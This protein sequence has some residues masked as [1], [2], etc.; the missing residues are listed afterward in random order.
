MRPDLIPQILLGLA[1][2]GAGGALLSYLSRGKNGAAWLKATPLQAIIY[3]AAIGAMLGVIGGPLRSTAH[4]SNEHTVHIAS[5]GDFQTKVL[6]A[7]QPV[8]VDFFATWCPPCHELAPTIERLS[9]EYAGKAVIAKVDV[10][11]V[12]EAAQ[13]F[14]IQS[15]PTVVLLKNGKEVERIIGL[16]REQYYRQKLDALLSDQ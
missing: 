14:G 10:D 13:Q 6:Q 5:M 7:D 12:G 4:A 9:S 16:D 15:L 1:I 8:L 2:G 11:Q 3:G